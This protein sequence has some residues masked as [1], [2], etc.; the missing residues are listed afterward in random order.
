MKTE[1]VDARA[2]RR[3]RKLSRAHC[4]LRLPATGPQPDIAFGAY[5]RGEY[6]AAF[7]EASRRASEQGDPVAMTLLGDLYSNG[8]GVPKDEKKALAWFSLAADRGQRE[9]IFALAMARFNGRGGPKDRAEAAALLEKAAKAG[10]VAAA[11]NLALL[12]LEGQDVPPNNARAVEL[13]THCR[14]CRK[15]GG[16]VRAR[17]P[18]Q[19]G[20]R[21]REGSGARPRSC[22]RLRRAAGVLDAEVEY[23]IALF[24]GTGVPKDESAAAALVPQGRAQGQS[25]RAEPAR[26]HP[27]DRPRPSGRPGRRG[28][29]AHHRAHAGHLGRLARD[30]HAETAAPPSARTPRRP[31]SSGSPTRAVPRS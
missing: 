5:Q 29:L 20:Q 3:P 17:D 22:C 28:A 19:G 31:P 13:L 1:P 18:L 25:D 23:A 30:L 12:Y 4:V 24:N 14:R 8:Y 26:A 7:K 11:Y 21:R 6:L 27:R 9:A 15:P 2:R 16:A 10:H